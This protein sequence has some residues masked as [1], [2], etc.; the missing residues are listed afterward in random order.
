MPV[1]GAWRGGSTPPGP[2]FALE[3]D[4]KIVDDRL[5]GRYVLSSGPEVTKGSF[6][7]RLVSNG[8]YS[9]EIELPA[10]TSVPQFDLVFPD[11]QYVR[12]T[13]KMNQR[14][15]QFNAAFVSFPQITVQAN[16]QP[17]ANGKQ[18]TARWLALG[19]TGLA[20]FKRVGGIAAAPKRRTPP[21][22][23]AA[24]AVAEEEEMAVPAPQPKKAAV[25]K[26]RAAK[27]KAPARR[28]PAAEQAAAEPLS[29]SPESLPEEGELE[30]VK[31]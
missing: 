26:K 17:A 18:F 9:I 22:R 23:A 24:P 21:A 5:E 19:L 30:E 8:V 27:R 10:G 28:A 31:E 7:G 2:E 20:R 15:P 11:K 4:S 1:P 29:D 25:K 13:L 16:L 14:Q 12:G 6:S 3:Y